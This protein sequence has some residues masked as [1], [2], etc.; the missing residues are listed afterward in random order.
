MERIHAVGRLEKAGQQVSCLEW[1]TGGKT[2]SVHDS[3]EENLS[4]SLK[5]GELWQGCGPTCSQL[6]Q[7]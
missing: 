1:D 7:L 6:D 5:L 3:G 2:C 4:R